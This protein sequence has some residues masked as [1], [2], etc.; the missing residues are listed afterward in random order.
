MT[1]EGPSDGHADPAPEQ[2]SPI[3]RQ[4]S[5]ARSSHRRVRR[6]LG[7]T[8][9]VLV[10]VLALAAMLVAGSM[11]S[12]RG[13]HEA[14]PVGGGH[15]VA[16]T[17]GDVATASAGVTGHHRPIVVAIVAGTSGTVAS[18]LLAPY[19]IFASSP[20]FHPNVVAAH[21]GPDVVRHSDVPPD[22]S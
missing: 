7:V 22:G 12:S 21:A 10:T 16:D 14:V 3:K 18:D 20:A 8:G 11:V 6:I 13:M 15:I 5:S 9:T 19:D 2:S 17:A 4:A 1:H